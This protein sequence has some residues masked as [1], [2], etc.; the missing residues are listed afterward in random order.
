MKLKW[1]KY[2]S[3]NMILLKSI[4]AN[5]SRNFIYSSLTIGKFDKYM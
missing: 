2:E 1:L 4:L 5:V 3:E